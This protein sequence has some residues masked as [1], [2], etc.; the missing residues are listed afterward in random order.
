MDSKNHQTKEKELSAVIVSLANIYKP[1][2]YLL[3]ISDNPKT[4]EYVNYIESLFNKSIVSFGLVIPWLK[5]NARRS[6]SEIIEQ[7]CELIYRDINEIAKRT[8]SDIVYQF[9]DSGGFQALTG[10]LT[11]DIV[12]DYIDLYHKAVE[13][14]VKEFHGKTINGKKV[15]IRCFTLDIPPCTKSNIE[16]G[17][18][19]EQSL[20]Y[21]FDSYLETEKRLYNVKDN[22][23]V[24]FHIGFEAIA[25]TFYEIFEQAPRLLDFPNWSTST[26]RKY[27]NSINNTISYVTVA[28]AYLKSL[29]IESKIKHFHYLGVSAPKF[30][31]PLFYLSKIVNWPF[32]TYDSSSQ[33]LSTVRGIVRLCLDGKRYRFDLKSDL[34]QYGNTIRKRLLEIGLDINL[35]TDTNRITKE[36]MQAIYAFGFEAL[37]RDEY[38]LDLISDEIVNCHKKNDRLCLLKVLGK[39][40]DLLNTDSLDYNV[41]SDLLEIRKLTKQKSIDKD[42]VLKLIKEHLEPLP[43]TS[44]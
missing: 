32:V 40:S 36:A 37:M 2:E 10:K 11:S 7:F 35:F 20:K 42:F 8:N 43:A 34:S 6:Q 39:Y 9:I 16:N 12:E 33:T 28:Y 5:N 31:L 13:Q 3:E 17:I 27:A 1:I 25:K 22:I 18:T 24:V 29:G 14:L 21:T 41:L 44:V 23:I 15:D 38:E 26:M 19:I 4:K 30:V